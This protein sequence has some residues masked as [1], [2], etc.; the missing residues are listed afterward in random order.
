MDPDVIVVGGG[1]A[2]L[3]CAR[4]LQAA[5]RR[6]LLL[7]AAD[8]VGGRVRT[9]EEGGFLLDRGFQVFLTA[10]PE[11]RRW[12][13][14]R[15]LDL[16]AIRPGALVWV[17]GRFHR[18]SDPFRRP[19]DLWAT[20]RAPVGTLRDKA[21]IGVLRWQ[22]KQGPLAA[23]WARPETTTMEALQA[24]GFGER[25]IR[26][27]LRPWLGGVFLDPELQTSNRMLEF[28]FR[29][30]ADGVAALPATGMQAIPRQLAAGLPAET[31]RCRTPVEAIDRTG[32]VLS[33]G[34]RQRARHVVVAT[35]GA[36]A[37]RLVP[38]VKAP[39][40]R[41]TVTLYFSAP[42]APVGEPS[43]VLN[44]SGRGRVNS[45]ME[46]SAV[47]PACAPSGQ[48]LISVSLLGNA[49]EDDAALEASVRRELGGWF[50]EDAVAPWV[51]KR[52]DRIRQA[53]PVRSPV[54]VDTPRPAREGLWL[55]GDH[56]ETASIE[57]AMHS[58]RAVADAL[59][60]RS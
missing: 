21:R 57:G 41:S 47:A 46:L 9:D 40:W 31:V 50:G 33:D 59:L 25:M 56:T 3:T 16:R 36:T 8:A 2:G 13:D 52:I 30:F 5:G 24:Q 7:E 37:A 6:A 27:F 34:T 14:Y 55:C 39:A 26:T 17:D 23:V 20:L 29:M 22:A 18:V 51:R 4:A 60:G 49:E 54:R 11:A 12:L 19:Q 1:L 53:L 43:L 28:V 45:V 42:A 32:V 38:G 44:G 48:S 58:G 15:A 10:Y 35:D